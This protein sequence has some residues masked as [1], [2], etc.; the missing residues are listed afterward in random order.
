M[1]KQIQLSKLSEGGLFIHPVSRKIFGVLGESGNSILIR[2]YNGESPEPAYL[3]ESASML[4]TPLNPNDLLDAMH[5]AINTVKGEVP[6]SCDP[7]YNQ[8]YYLRYGAD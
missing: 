8:D 2:S 3:A 4:V 5:E 6:S 1:N 7:F